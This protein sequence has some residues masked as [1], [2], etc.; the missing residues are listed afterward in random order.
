[1][2]RSPK[3]PAEG[4]TTTR[5]VNELS[6]NAPPCRLSRG[7]S[8]GVHKHNRRKN[9][10]CAQG[11]TMYFTVLWTRLRGPLAL[12]ASVDT[13]PSC[14]LYRRRAVSCT[15]R[16]IF[17]AWRHRGLM[18][19]RSGLG[20]PARTP[21]VVGFSATFRRRCSGKTPSGW[22]T[23]AFQLVSTSASSVRG[24]ALSRGRI[25][26]MF[27]RASH[28]AYHP[29]EVLR[30]AKRRADVLTSEGEA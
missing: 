20:W 8:P 21:P 16:A 3:P 1:M 30:A 19:R 9:D 18:V 4:P 11:T 13:R 5:C 2:E 22:S 7:C 6:A 28:E 17:P 27:S 29:A 12:T 26:R 23:Q 15:L 10:P 24:H 25:P 14:C